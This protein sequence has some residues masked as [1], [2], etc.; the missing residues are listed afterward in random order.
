MDEMRGEICSNKL[1]DRL[2]EC[3]PDLHMSAG[4]KQDDT[5]GVSEDD[6]GNQGEF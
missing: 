3:Y 6:V 5:I 1:R 4:C 2:I